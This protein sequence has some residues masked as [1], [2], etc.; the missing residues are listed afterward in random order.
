MIALVLALVGVQAV[1][2]SLG[3]VLPP[4]HLGPESEVVAVFR[5]A[6]SVSAGLDGSVYVVE[7]ADHTLV[8][9][10]P[11][12]VRSIVALSGLRPN[13]VDASSGLHFVIAD[14]QNGHVSRIGR[15][16]DLIMQIVVTS[17][18]GDDLS[19]DPGFVSRSGLPGAGE[20][21]GTPLDV[22]Q[23]ASGSIVAIE[24]TRENI[25]FWDE[26]GRS[27][28]LVRS[29]EGIP[30]QPR[31]LASS[32][33]NVLV[34]DAGMPGVFV[35]DGFGTAAGR[36]AQDLGVIQAVAASPSDIWV[37]S[38]GFLAR[39]NTNGQVMTVTELDIEGAV[40][41]MAATS[42]DLFLLTSRRLMRLPVTP[43]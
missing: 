21:A 18:A 26:S 11:S 29:F 4:A 14:A 3:A 33:A 42:Q 12:G 37:V 31:H 35:Y 15:A 41:D 1:P 17:K 36:F 5:D 39:L 32:G 34:A 23:T 10:S 20:G 2:D 7:A 22:T 27:V 19:E 16:G 8:Q 40:V 6:V 9:I 38:G 13:A 28:R 25:L 24:S 43:R 30:L